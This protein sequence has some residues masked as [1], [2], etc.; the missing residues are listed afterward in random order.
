MKITGVRLTHVV[1][2]FQ[3][4]SWH[5]ALASYSENRG[6]LV[7]L[8]TADG[9]SGIG[10]A[11]AALHLGEVLEG[12]QAAI[13]QL[14][15][16]VLV[17]KDPFA[18][19]ALMSQID[20][21]V[22]GY[23]RSKAA[24][25]TALY[26]LVGKA[27]GVPVYQLL[28]GLVR[29]SI[30]AV[31]IVPIKEP[32]EMAREALKVVERG[33]R[34]L[35]VKVGVDPR[36]DVQRVAAI[37]QAVGP[38]VGLTLDANQG[39]SPRAAIEVL[40]QVERYGIALIEQPVRSDDYAGLAQVKAGQSIVVEADESARSLPDI[41]RLA[42]EGC[43]DAVSLKTPKL[44]GIRN[45][46]RGAAICQAANLR[47]RMGMGGAS[48]I[49]SA[50]DMHV[51]AS[52][53]NIDFACEVAEFDRVEFDPVEGLEVVDGVLRVPTGPGLGVR[54]RQAVAA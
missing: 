3:D 43:V 11:T 26:D 25:E 28:G 36:L 5:F 17:G 48:R 41:F 44:G 20:A 50:V 22:L 13:E 42:C 27:L 7:E 30:P 12:M 39:W 54:V 29:E 46:K 31:R 35:K 37:R 21:T 1:Q 47:C 40:R 18:I 49:A 45:V 6:I 51:I 33:Y 53:P 10:Y 16:P 8:Q 38:E 2:P 23:N 32:P 15:G 4:K 19:E 52:T 14:F 24:I 9:V 34:Y